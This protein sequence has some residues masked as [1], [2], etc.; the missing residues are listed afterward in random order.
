M[1]TTLQVVEIIA[2]TSLSVLCVTL[3]VV[4]IR[5]RR[6]LEFMEKDFKLFSAKAM[7]VLD[8][9]E[10]ITERVKTITETIGEQADALKHMIGSF[11]QA[12][13]NIVAFERRIQDSIEEPLMGAVD[14]FAAIFK[15]IQAFLERIPFVGRLRAE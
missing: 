6:I 13:D 9:L 10:V 3:V 8:N 12:A 1:E 5:V 15:G 2:F 4:L 11:T 7:P 14:T